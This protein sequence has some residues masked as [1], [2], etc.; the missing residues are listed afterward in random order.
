MRRA[1]TPSTLTWPK[2][3]LVLFAERTNDWNFLEASLRVFLA[4]KYG[5][6]GLIVNDLFLPEQGRA[7]FDVNNPDADMK[8]QAIRDAATHATQLFQWGFYLLLPRHQ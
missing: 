3:I 5:I 6:Y 4:H 2:S 1:D 8:R 7:R